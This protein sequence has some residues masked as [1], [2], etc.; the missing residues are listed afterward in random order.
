MN[1]QH[2][3]A[4]SFD[5]TDQDYDTRDTLLYALALGLGSDPLDDDELPYVY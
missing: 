3:V 4:R 1:L 5:A 2:V